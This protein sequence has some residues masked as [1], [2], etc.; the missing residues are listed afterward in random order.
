M[1]KEEIKKKVLEYN[2]WEHW[3]DR[4]FGAFVLSLMA[5]GYQTFKTIGLNWEQKAFLFQNGAFY[6]SLKVLDIQVDL[7]I[8]NKIGLFEVVSNCEKFYESGKKRVKYIL[9]SSDRVPDKL[10]E[11]RKLI[12]EN[13]A[14]TWLT[15][16]FEHLYLNKLKLE[17]PKYYQGDINKFI[18]DVS[19]P[20]KKNK[21]SYFLEALLGD[22]DL[23]K[24][25]QEFGWIKIRDGFGEPYSIEE[26]SSERQRLKKDGITEKF[27]RPNVP[28]ELSDLVVA[29]QELV[30]FR[31]FRTDVLWEF[32]YRLRPI[33]KEVAS[34]YKIKFEDLKWYDFDSLIS[35]ELK[36]Y[37]NVSCVGMGEEQVLFE[38]P[39]LAISDYADV[40][41]LKGAIAY[42]GVL[43][44]TV[45]IV[46]TA[47]EI[48]KVKE[49]D[50][51]V[52]PTTAP[53]YIIGMNKASAFITDEGGITSHAAIVAREM[54]KPCIIGTK[55]ATKVLKDG[56]L[57]EVDAEKGVVKIIKSS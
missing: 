43:R 3:A 44:G 21:H 8:K 2:D 12:R 13:I 14:Y 35:G 56:D 48:E 34:L 50:I 20:V 5:N 23:E 18:G 22:D 42:K 26:L 54:K 15:H 32:M 17:I 45:K 40:K 1:E 37:K 53:S 19:Y 46:M 47:Y 7:L 41:E 39:I 30:Y 16:A 49:G 25:Q 29:T 6:K 10:M 9:D 51:L 31:T 57:V 28:D 52:A 24:I 33:L 36:F 4:P 55:I 27:N 11:I 38:G